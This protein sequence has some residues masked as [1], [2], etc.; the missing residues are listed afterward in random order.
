MGQDHAL[1]TLRCQRL[2]DPRA[3]ARS[4][5]S[6]D[7]RPRQHRTVERSGHGGARR[8]DVEWA[9]PSR[10]HVGLYQGRD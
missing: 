9:I 10:R 8:G 2:G 6:L 3:R 4:V 1:A 5:L 7:R